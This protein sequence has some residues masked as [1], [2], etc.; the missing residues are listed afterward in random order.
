MTRDQINEIEKMRL[1]GI[2]YVRIAQKT[3]I[4]ENTVKSYCRRHPMFSEKQP[5]PV[6]AFCRKP[7]E[8]HP[9]RKTKR[10]CSDACRMKWW[11]SHPELVKRK[12]VYEF[13][14]PECGTTFTAYGNS[15]RKYCSHACYISARF[16]GASHE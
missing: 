7:V 9:H 15:G 11:N 2:G 12:A 5:A 8:Q 6:C 4:P 13:T 1:S 3:G 16:G 10:F 14:C